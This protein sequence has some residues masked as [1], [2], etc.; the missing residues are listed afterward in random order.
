VLPDVLVLELVPE[1]CEALE[2]RLLLPE[3]VDDADALLEVF[4]TLEVV[5]LL[6]GL[7]P[8]PCG[9]LD[10]LLP[11]GNEALNVELLETFGTDE[12][13]TALVVKFV[14]KDATLVGGMEDGGG[15]SGASLDW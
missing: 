5:G 2:L 7:A 1:L 11:D 13:E 8:V 4:A 12:E 9:A 10:V 3:L 14:S 15:S 6:G